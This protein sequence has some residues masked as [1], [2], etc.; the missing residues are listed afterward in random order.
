GQVLAV[1]PRAAC[2]SRSRRCKPASLRRKPSLRSTAPG[3]G[4]SGGCFGP[5]LR[6][7]RANLHHPCLFLRTQGTAG[8]GNDLAHLDHRIEGTGILERVYGRGD[9]SAAGDVV[10]QPPHRCSE[11][12]GFDA[13]R[14]L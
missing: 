13:E 10:L 12:V 6:D 2:T 3:D 9:I 4:G 14:E 8:L 5:S 11:I 7:E 1:P